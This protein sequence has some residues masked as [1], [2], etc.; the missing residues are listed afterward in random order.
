MRLFPHPFGKPL[1]HF[2]DGSFH[3]LRRLFCPLG[4]GFGPCSCSF[5][6]LR[7]LLRPTRGA[8]GLLSRC[9]VS[10][11]RFGLPGRTPGKYCYPKESSDHDA[12]EFPL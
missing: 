4:N 12:F 3:S 6:S 2:E 11:R 10:C 7:R 9:I 5:G 1:L 8:R